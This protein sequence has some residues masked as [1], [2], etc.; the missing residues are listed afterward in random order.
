MRQSNPKSYLENNTKSEA[1]LSA[2]LA[3][4]AGLVAT[5]AQGISTVSVAL[6]IQE[7]QQAAFNNSEELQAIHR[8]LH[9][10]TKE[11]KKIKKGLNIS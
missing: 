11:V 9:E 4:I 6:A 3:V 10:L 2:T 1:N 8:Q 7:E 5:L